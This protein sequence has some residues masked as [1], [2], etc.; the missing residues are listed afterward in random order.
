MA[1]L[2]IVIPTRNRY[3]SLFPV[4]ETL[5]DKI[6][7]DDYEIVVQDNTPDNGD[8]VKFFSGLCDPRVKYHHTPGKL[9][10]SA[11]TEIALGRAKG[12]YLLFIGD[13]DFVTPHVL[14]IVEMMRR[15]GIDTLAYK[16]AGYCWSNLEVKRPNKW[17]RAG[18][19]YITGSIS[20]KATIMPIEETLNKMLDAGA[21]SVYPMPNVY[22]GI[23]S[24]KVLRRMYEANG[25]RYVVG[26]CPDMNLAVSLAANVSEYCYL[27]YPVSTNGV[28]TR[29]GSGLYANKAHRA[30]LEAMVEDGWLPQEVIDKWNPL[31]AR[32]WT[33][34]TIYAQAV[35][36]TLKANG[37]DKEI[38][39]A[40][41]YAECYRKEFWA[42]R[43]INKAVGEAV[44]QKKTTR[45]AIV[46]SFVPKLAKGILGPVL[47]PVIGRILG[48]RPEVRRYENVST[49]GDCMDIISQIPLETA[50]VG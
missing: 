45:T 20:G 18:S 3:E 5:I 1:A 15:R 16:A 50:D 25:G 8:A 34:L 35:D 7:G 12:D 11:N 29:S 37:I 10:Q 28:T 42:Y 31:F 21:I 43:E 47:R 49:I 19:L 24:R 26:S 14:R 39:Y 46:V 6:I 48:I 4:I 27:E 9:S 30:T 40:Q 2:S 41:H 33:A 38:N 32:V 44:R 23:V 22:H 13:D 17:N 36:E